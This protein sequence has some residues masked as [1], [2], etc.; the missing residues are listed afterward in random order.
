[1]AFWW[2]QTRRTGLWGQSAAFSFTSRTINVHV[3]ENRRH[4]GN[5]MFFYPAKYRAA[6]GRWQ[7]LQKLES[8]WKRMAHWERWEIA[9]PFGNK[10]AE[11]SKVICWTC[12]RVN[13][14]ERRLH[15][16]YRERPNLLSSCPE[17]N[18]INQLAKCFSCLLIGGLSFLFYKKHSYSSYLGSQGL[19]T[20]LSYAREEGQ[21]NLEEFHPE[22]LDTA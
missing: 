17:I 15:C 2:R 13:R 5:K 9:V 21:T 8:P 11:K 14:M 3:W 20:T 16:I 6:H 19:T 4:S 1:M 18:G 10:Q 12:A 7:G 22:P